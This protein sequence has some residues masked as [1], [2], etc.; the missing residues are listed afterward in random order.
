MKD[1]KK[2][3]NLYFF[4]DYTLS[5]AATIVYNLF[6]CNNFLEV[7]DIFGTPISG[8][9]LIRALLLVPIF[10]CCLYFFTGSY[11]RSLYEKSRLTELTATLLHSF[12]GCIILYFMPNFSNLHGVE[13]FC[14]Y[15]IIQVFFISSGRT[16]LLFQ[17]KKT[18][19]RGQ[20]YFNTLMVGN[21]PKSVNIFSA[22]DRNFRYLGFK[23]IGFC[24]VYSDEIR[25]GLAKWIPHLGNINQV[26]K[27]VA[28]YYIE[29]VIISIDKKDKHLIEELISNL[30]DQEVDIKLIPDTIDILSGS[31]KSSNI[32]GAMLIDIQT[33]ALSPREQHIKRLIDI[34]V[35]FTALVI[36]SPLLL[37]FILKTIFSSSGGAIYKQERIG[38][39][40]KPF[41]IFK[42][43]SMYSDAEKN[44]PA[45]S[46][47]NDERITTWGKTM[48]KWRLDE[49]PQLWNILIGNMSLVGP[50]PERKPYI[51]LL[52]TKTPYYR[53]LFKAK[54][55]LTSWGMVQFGYASNID[56][57]IERMQYDLIYIENASLL[58]DF[59]ILMHTLR[60]I[61]SGKG[62]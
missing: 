27:I 10:W 24:S 55:G 31:V 33:T 18:L 51:D 38:Y 57:M 6:F 44:G 35:S 59:K 4:S 1:R 45:L 54:P 58:L 2:N 36:L 11:N 9:R 48:R 47:D 16:I 13:Q 43:R 20:V 41:T 3:I 29:R 28:E 12:F 19:K 26:K 34:V 17:T 8:T 25:N 37:F 15:L 62:K 50:R 23:T 39:K 22:L 21:N 5:L 30:T 53:Y 49:L 14:V 52:I 56:E 60:I 7:I 32:L 42:F 40:G 46:S 61:L